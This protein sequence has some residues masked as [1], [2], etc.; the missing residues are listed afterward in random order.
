MDFKNKVYKIVET[1]PKGK[2][3]TYKQIAQKIGIKGYRAIGQA[4]KNNPCSP[5]IPCH[6]VVKSNGEIGG[7]FG[8][9]DGAEIKRKINLLKNEGIKITRGKIENFEKVKI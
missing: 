5:K 9:I 3:S 6:R 4:L 1:I 8:K 2:V 7:F